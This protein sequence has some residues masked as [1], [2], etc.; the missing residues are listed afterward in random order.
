MHIPAE[1]STR[2]DLSKHE[3]IRDSVM[4]DETTDDDQRLTRRQTLIRVDVQHREMER[5]G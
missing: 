1:S 5:Q 4:I 3:A 2:A